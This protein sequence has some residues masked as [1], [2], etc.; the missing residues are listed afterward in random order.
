MGGGKEKGMDKKNFRL[1]KSAEKH[2]N[3]IKVTRLYYINIDNASTE[4]AN[5]Q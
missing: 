1:R 3:V 5:K 2:R 4:A